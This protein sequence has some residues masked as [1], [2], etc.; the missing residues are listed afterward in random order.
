MDDVYYCYGGLTPAVD[1]DVDRQARRSRHG[2]IV[3]H[4]TED[5][6]S[7][8]FSLIGVK[9]TTARLMAEKAIDALIKGSGVPAPAS[10]SEELPLPGGAGYT[11]EDDLRRALESATGQPASDE[12]RYFLQT[13]GT[14]FES[15]MQIGE[16]S[17]ADGENAFFRCRVRYAIRQEMAVRL[18]DVIFRRSD[19]IT[20][21][22]LVESELLWASGLMA[23][24]LGWSPERHQ[25]ELEDT[26][27]EIADRYAQI[28]R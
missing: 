1:G 22:K 26:K 5:G 13:F 10:R 23:T 21:G 25:Q 15:A 27:A 14:N 20:R 4:A 9:Y 7:G 16:W 17:S 6:V 18:S 8:L 3:D 28:V 12:G 24:E 11:S 19:R 2:M